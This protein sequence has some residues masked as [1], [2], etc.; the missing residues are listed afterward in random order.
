MRQ[1]DDA[2][3]VA[4]ARGQVD[5]ERDAFADEKL[6][7]HLYQEAGAVAGLR[8]GAA[9]PAMAQVDQRL[10]SL[11]DYA[12][13]LDAFDVGH[14]S[15]ATGVVLEAWVVQTLLGGPLQL[16][17]SVFTGHLA[18]SR[19]DVGERYYSSRSLGAK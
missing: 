3:A 2:D 8:V 15:D 12:V 1:E 10:E 5:A 14:Q 7:R 13:G 16:F 6:V 17:V 19:A 9:G 18:L 11:V 4:T